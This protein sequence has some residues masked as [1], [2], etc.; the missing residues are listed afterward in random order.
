MGSFVVSLQ[1]I[2]VFWGD[3]EIISLDLTNTSAKK[4]S[5][6]EWS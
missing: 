4:R 5:N 1:K 3:L 6:K 2:H